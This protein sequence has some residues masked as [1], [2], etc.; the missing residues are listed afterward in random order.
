MYLLY[1][2]SQEIFIKE[3]ETSVKKYFTHLTI[4]TD[5]Y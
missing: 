1:I 2:L 5:K 4:K 3:K